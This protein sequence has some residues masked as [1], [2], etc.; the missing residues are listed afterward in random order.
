MLA[1]DP[2]EGPGTVPP[3]TRTRTSVDVVYTRLGRST[4]AVNYGEDPSVPY[5]TRPPESEDQAETLWGV[6]Q[7]RLLVEARFEAR[8]LPQLFA[9]AAARVERVDDEERGVDRYAWPQLTL[10]WGLPFPSLRY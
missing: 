1:P 6:R 9:G 5:E 8:L 3:S 2:V 4:D 10:R 7:D